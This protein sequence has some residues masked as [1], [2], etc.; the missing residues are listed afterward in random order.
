MDAGLWQSNTA[1][2][3]Y[4]NPACETD[5]R[6]FRQCMD[7]NQGNLSICGWYLDQLVGFPLECRYMVVITV[8]TGLTES[9]P[10]RC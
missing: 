3:S 10:G 8:L 2:S 9:V 5:V 6:N 4:G 1:N 7:E